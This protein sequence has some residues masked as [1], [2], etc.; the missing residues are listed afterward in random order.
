MRVRYINHKGKEIDFMQS[1]YLFQSGNLLDFTWQ[2]ELKRGLKSRIQGLQKSDVPIPLSVAIVSDTVQ[3]FEKFAYELNEVTETDVL[4]EIP[5]R[6]YVNDYY[7]KC[8][9]L[10][11]MPTDWNKGIPYIKRNLQVLPDYPFWCREITKKFFRGYDTSMEESKGDGVISYPYGYPYMYGMP[12]DI[13]FVLNDHYAP[14][15]FQM[16]IYGPCENPAIRIDG[17]LYEVMSTL[18]DGDF[19]IID[20]RDNSVICKKSDTS[21]INMFNFRNKDSSLFKK[22]PAGRCSVSWRKDVFGFDITLFQERSEPK[23]II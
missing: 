3:E 21:S 11:D 10:Q 12:K 20:S 4:A 15:D 14:C 22:I 9:V 6:L 5:G 8:Y 19:L 16:I 23:W 13:S 1:P 2:Y 17:H 7:L 18:Y